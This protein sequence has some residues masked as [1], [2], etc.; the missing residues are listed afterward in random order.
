MPVSAAGVCRVAEPEPTKAAGRV[1][2]FE[3][4][5]GHPAPGRGGDRHGD[6]WQ[7][8]GAIAPEDDAIERAPVEVQRDAGRAGGEVVQEVAAAGGDQE[9]IAVPARQDG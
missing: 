2:E 7:G 8:A 5:G 1:H 3:M 4:G 6:E 9:R